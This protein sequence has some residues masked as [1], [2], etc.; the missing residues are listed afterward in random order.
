MLNCL[1][2][3]VAYDKVKEAL[4]KKALQMS[5]CPNAD[6]W[7]AL[8]ELGIQTGRDPGEWDRVGFLRVTDP[9]GVRFPSESC[10]RYGV[11]YVPEEMVDKILV[12]GALP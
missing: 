3:Q 4:K 6:W 7:R 10:T 1:N 12:L 2:H 11:L 9:V 8:K 5:P